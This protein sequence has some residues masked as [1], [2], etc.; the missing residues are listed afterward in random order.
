MTQTRPTRIS[1]FWSVSLDWERES[2]ITHLKLCTLKGIVSHFPGPVFAGSGPSENRLS[3]HP[4]SCQQMSPVLEV[5][6]AG[7]GQSHEKTL[8]G[9]ESGPWRRGGVRRGNISGGGRS[10]SLALLIPRTEQELLLQ[11]PHFVLVLLLCP[12]THTDACG[13]RTS[14]D[15]T[16]DV[17]ASE[18]NRERRSVLPTWELSPRAGTPGRPSGPP[19]SVLEKP[20]S[21]PQVGDGC[22]RMPGGQKQSGG[23]QGTC[24]G[25]VLAAPPPVGR[26]WD[27]TGLP[28]DS[29]SRQRAASPLF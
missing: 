16:E 4:E 17:K 3:G 13:G 15:L 18:M 8:T 26:L 19:C 2:R 14:K 11:T 24:A 10:A 12:V 7:A 23:A 20:S 22:P 29:S 21:P 27:C 28:W 9:A 5:A 1:L 6:R 25:L